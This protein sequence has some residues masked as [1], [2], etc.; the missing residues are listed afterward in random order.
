M[1]LLVFFVVIADLLAPPAASA[2]TWRRPVEG[3]VLR[4]FVVGP[5]RFAPGSHRGVDLGAPVGTPVRAACGGRASFVGRV[6][7]GGLTLSVRCGTLVSTYQH[8]GGAV[9]R[10]GGVVLR[11]AV[12]GV[13]GRSGTPRSRRPHLHLGAR[14]AVSGRYVDP[15]SLIR[16]APPAI[17]PLAPRV[18]SARPLPLGPAPAPPAPSGRPLP[19]GPAPAPPAPSVRPLPLG[20]APA[21]RAMRPRAAR[22]S[23]PLAAPA[24]PVPARGVP[25]TVWAGLG[26]VAVGLPFGGFV[27]VRRRRR[28]ALAHVAQTA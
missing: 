7:G 8:L 25:L 3:T 15:M 28:R 26:C 11:G 21:P 14:E 22:Y 2:S 27:T 10:R 6:P 12:V 4:P 20:P 16:D 19:L 23:R 17:P 24:A 13:V 9:V 5:D 18:P 1:A